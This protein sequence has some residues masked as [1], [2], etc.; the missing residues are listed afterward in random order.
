[1]RLRAQQ[2]M[3]LLVA[4]AALA[5]PQAPAHAAAACAGHQLL[6][7]PRPEAS[8]ETATPQIFVSPDKAMHALV[9]PADVSLDT[10][11]DMESRVVVRTTKGDTVTSRDHSSPRG[12]NGY[13]V[14]R[15]KWSPDSH[16]FVYS[17]ISSG[18]HSPWSFPMMVFSRKKAL[19]ASFSDM[20]N[21]NP[22]TAGE[23]TF[24][25][26]HSVTATTW[27]KEGAPEER[28]P[29]TVDLGQAFEKLPAAN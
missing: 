1:M 28:V 4:M 10:T 5:M 16:F 6:S 23:F 24:S 17:L 25:G 11:P 18:G 7:K 14:Y 21:G 3:L 26:P 19:I 12:M 22:T 29:I 13:Y 8:C 20:I 15:A 27:K 9:L 2:A